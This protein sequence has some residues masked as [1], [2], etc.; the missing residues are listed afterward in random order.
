MS[1]EVMTCEFCGEAT[2]T[3]SVSLAIW[4][5]QGLVLVEDIPAQVCSDCDEQFYDEA[6]QTRLRSLATGGFS[7][8][9][10]VRELTVP[11]FSLNEEEAPAKDE[12]AA[13]SV[14]QDAERQIA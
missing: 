1:N 6:T 3:D 9:R 10:K 7:S 12:A 14:S 13:A 2:S 11:V 5:A 4:S 8:R